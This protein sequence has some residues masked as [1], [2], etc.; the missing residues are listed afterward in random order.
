MV[1]TVLNSDNSYL[2]ESII[3]SLISGVLSGVLVAFVNNLL[4]RNK[5]QAE[6]EKLMAE[7]EKL[8]AEAEKIRVEITSYILKE[9]ILF[10]GSKGIQN[11]DIEV[12]TLNG[13]TLNLLDF[14]NG[15]LILDRRSI[16]NSPC[17]LKLLTY[18]SKKNLDSISKKQVNG[19]RRFRVSFESIVSNGNHLLMFAFVDNLT[20]TLLD[21]IR[22]K[23]NVELNQSAWERFD[24]VFKVPS[25]KDCRLDIFCLRSSEPSIL[26]IRN[27]MILENVG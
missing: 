3:I 8:K 1:Q 22:G 19:I 27:L 18:G 9:E 20:G 17:R 6:T 13:N 24:L 21:S 12:T 16:T 5:T 14:D 2:M 25:D 15:N 10:D 4:V 23:V 11:Y 26:K 7:A